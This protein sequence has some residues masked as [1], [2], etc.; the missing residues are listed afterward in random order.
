MGALEVVLGAKI[1]HCGSL[2]D[3]W[4]PEKTSPEKELKKGGCVSHGWGP[5]GDHFNL[6]FDDVSVKFSARFLMF[7]SPFG[8]ILGG[9]NR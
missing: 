9:N 4:H 7:W 6:I 3:P 2:G 8:V 1:V 5:F